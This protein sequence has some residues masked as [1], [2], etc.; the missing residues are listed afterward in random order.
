MVARGKKK[1]LYVEG[2]SSSF[3][4]ESF[5]TQNLKVPREAE[6]N[7][8][9]SWCVKGGRA[10]VGL[11]TS[12]L[13]PSAAGAPGTCRW[14]CGFLCPH[15]V[16]SP[17]VDTEDGLQWRLHGRTFLAS[18]VRKKAHRRKPPTAPKNPDPASRPGVCS[19][20]SSTSCGSCWLSVV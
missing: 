18:F 11:L 2:K 13:A 3:P 1:L 8:L 14:C 4:Q 15:T 17:P 12:V 10:K 9:W 20:S 7:G 5:R 19:T 16:S 6:G